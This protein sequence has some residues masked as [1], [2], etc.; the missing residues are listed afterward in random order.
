LKYWKAC[1][2][3]LKQTSKNKSIVLTVDTISLSKAAGYF[4]FNDEDNRIENLRQSIRDICVPEP[5]QSSI[6]VPN[7]VHTS[8]LRFIKKPKDPKKFEEKF[9]RICEELLEKTKKIS[10]EI[11][12]ICLAFETRPYMHIDCD[13]FHV[14]DII[15]C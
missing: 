10:F 5:G 8:F 3:Q 7:I 14:L 4:C 6:H 15:K 13:E 12:E 11:D 1:F 2:N 9:H